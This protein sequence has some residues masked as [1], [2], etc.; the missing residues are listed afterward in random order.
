M[1]RFREALIDITSRREDY[2]RYGTYEGDLSEKASVISFNRDPSSL[3]FKDYLRSIN[4]S[5]RMF[6]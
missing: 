1:G 5:Q 2:V 6:F 3:V 4:K